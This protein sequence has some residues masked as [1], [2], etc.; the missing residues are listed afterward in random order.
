MRL[1]SKMLVIVVLAMCVFDASLHLLEALANIV[2]P[3]FPSRE[4][5]TIFWVSYWFGAAALLSLALWIDD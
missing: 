4:I 2:W 1:L 3:I 5:Y